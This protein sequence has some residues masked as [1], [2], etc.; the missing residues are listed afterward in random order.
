LTDAIP[1]VLA[2]V[3]ALKVLEREVVGVADEQLGM[4]IRTPHVD[5]AHAAIQK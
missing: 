2:A 4:L 5:H 1:E 3:A